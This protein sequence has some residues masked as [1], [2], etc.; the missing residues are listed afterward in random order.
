MR[1]IGIRAAGSS[2]VAGPMTADGVGAAPEPAG[3][4]EQHVGPTKAFYHPQMKEFL[5]MYDDARAAT[6]PKAAVLEFLQTAYDA[7]ATLAK[8]DRKALER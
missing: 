4:A 8:W 6:S 5:L 3:F 7:A 2:A 1:A